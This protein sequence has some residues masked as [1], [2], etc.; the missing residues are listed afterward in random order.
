LMPMS[1]SMLVLL[2]MQASHRPQGFA[3]HVSA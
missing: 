1:I 2:C 3:L